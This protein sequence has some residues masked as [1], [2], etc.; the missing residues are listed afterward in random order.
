MATLREHLILG[1]IV[2]PVPIPL[3]YLGSLS[4]I[5][6]NRAFFLQ[7]K[8]RVLTDI[9]GRIDRQ[10]GRIYGFTDSDRMRDHYKGC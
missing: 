2:L 7:T 5:L 1:A 3:L 4:T 9:D 10:T 6:S 8:K